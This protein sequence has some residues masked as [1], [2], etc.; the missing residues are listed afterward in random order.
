MTIDKRGILLTFQ[1]MGSG[2]G[3]KMVH[4]GLVS[5]MKPSH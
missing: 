4:W 1:H 5:E 3:T 2:E